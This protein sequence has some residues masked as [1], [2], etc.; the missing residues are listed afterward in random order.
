[1]KVLK[2]YLKNISVSGDL[3][4]VK[5]VLESTGHY[6]YNLLG[7][8]LDNGLA[9]F[10]A[11]PLHTSFYRKSLILKKTKTDKG[12]AHTIASIVMSDMRLKPCP[13]HHITTKN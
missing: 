12:D 2:P 5:A 8:L 6:S 10:V 1:M 9:T 4:K 13:I 7:F 3:T 11:N